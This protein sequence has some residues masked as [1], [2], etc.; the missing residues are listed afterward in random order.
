MRAVQPNHTIRGTSPKLLPFVAMVIF[1]GMVSAYD[2][3]LVV[4]NWDVIETSEQNP[5]CLYLIQLGH[6]DASIFLR[7]KSG[8][9]L[10][11]LSV[12]G[13]IYRRNKEKAHWVAGGLSAFQGGLLMYLF[14]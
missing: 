3:Y 14:R 9:T 8:G 13:A 12:M 11:V 10:V 5:A 1:V 6:G 7:A 2:A 4:S